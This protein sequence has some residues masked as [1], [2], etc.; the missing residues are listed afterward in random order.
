MI[1]I[2][3]RYP[4]LMGDGKVKRISEKYLFDAVSFADGE[5][6]VKSVVKP[7]IHGDGA[8][9][10]SDMGVAKFSDYILGDGDW[11][12]EISVALLSYDE[13]KKKETKQVIKDLVQATSIENAIKTWK[14]K[15]EQIG[16][17]E[18]TGVKRSSIEEVFEYDPEQA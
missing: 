10:I 9:N 3:A 17:Y 2:K 7:F 8:V 11:F 6:Q 13:V 1:V 15:N 18:I 12:Y 5:R 16:G 4:K 14:E